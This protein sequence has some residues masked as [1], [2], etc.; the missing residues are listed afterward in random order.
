MKLL[1]IDK[2]CRY[3]ILTFGS[4]T[5]GHHFGGGCSFPCEISKGVFFAP[6]RLLRKE[7]VLI[8]ITL[9]YIA[10]NYLQWLHTQSFL[11][12]VCLSLPLLDYVCLISVDNKKDNRL[13]RKQRL[14]F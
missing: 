6:F 14:S 8:T 7:L 13:P 1:S 11:P 2:L 12:S 3:D 4:N 5:R 10:P 9:F